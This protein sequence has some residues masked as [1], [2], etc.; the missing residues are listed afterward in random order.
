MTAA[1]LARGAQTAFLL[2][3]PVGALLAP[4][5]L[6]SAAQHCI[7]P[8]HGAGSWRAA[9][10]KSRANGGKVSSRNKSPASFKLAPSD[11]AFLYE[12]CKSCFYKKAHKTLFRP[13]APFPSI[14]GTIDLEMKRHLR[15][16]RTTD[17]LPDM[18]PGV[19]LCE[20]DDAWVECTPITPPGRSSSVYIRGMVRCT[21]VYQRSCI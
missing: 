15:G 17:V 14:F 13:R 6:P 4:A 11:F 5:S 8:A 16:L 19:F 18:K 7:A 21:S 10:S 3:A 12:E 20:D 2:A 1:I 9:A